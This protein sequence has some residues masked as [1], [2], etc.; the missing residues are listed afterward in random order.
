MSFLPIS[1]LRMRHWVPCFLLGLICLPVWGQ[2]LVELSPDKKSYMPGDTIKLMCRVP[3][4]ENTQRLG[5]LNLLIEDKRHEQVWKF[6]YP[7]VEGYFDAEFVVPDTF[8]DGEYFFTADIQPVFFQLTGRTLKKEDT[9]SLRY[10]MLLENKTMIAGKVAVNKE[11]NFRMPRHVFSGRATLYFSPYETAKK[12]KNTIDVAIVTPLDS[13]Y[14]PIGQ[15][16]FS[17]QI[18]DKR[19]NDVISRYVPDT[20]FLQNQQK[21]T[22][23]NV[24]VTAKGKTPEGKLD[25][26]YTTGSFTSENS[27]IFGG[28]EDEF[29]GNI[30]ILDY[31]QSRVAGLNIV[32]DTEE[33]GGYWVSWRNEPTAFFIDELPVDLQGIVSI[34]VSEIAMVK[35]FKPPFNGGAMGSGGGAIAIYTKRATT[36]Q[37]SR[38]KNRF[39]IQGFSPTVSTLTVIKP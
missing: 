29:A 27:V 4:W 26:T 16:T 18:G 17:L 31:L 14:S 24:T 19:D 15:T 32:R 11:G 22:L 2:T 25:E 30:N 21:G 7:L 12:A 35:I 10:T 1:F 13:S 28:M 37:P 6:R 34:P 23:S 33:F 20:A 38:F 8:P 36:G 3:D 5:T 9:D 39:V